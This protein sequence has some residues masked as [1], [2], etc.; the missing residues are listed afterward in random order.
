MSGSP[1]DTPDAF[2]FRLE[3]LRLRRH[4]HHV[5]ADTDTDTDTS[6]HI[7]PMTITI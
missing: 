5:T 2:F 3:R 6:K 4:K 7:L 1:V